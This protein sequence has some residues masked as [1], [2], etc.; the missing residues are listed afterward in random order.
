MKGKSLLSISDLSSKDIRSLISQA[1]DM[2]A[3]GWLSVLSGKTL[4]LL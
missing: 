4:A 2:K 1:A 3:A